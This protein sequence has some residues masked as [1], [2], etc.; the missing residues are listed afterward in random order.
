VD[1]PPAD[2]KRLG[3]PGIGGGGRWQPKGPTAVCST[4]AVARPS[5]HIRAP[6]FEAWGADGDA[7]PPQSSAPRYPAESA[8]RLRPPFATMEKAA[9]VC[10]SLGI[11]LRLLVS[12]RGG[13]V[14]LRGATLTWCKRPFFLDAGN[15]SGRAMRV[16]MR[17][18]PSPLSRV[19][20]KPFFRIQ[21][22]L[23][24][25]M[26]WHRIRTKMVG[27]MVCSPAPIADTG[28]RRRGSPAEPQPPPTWA[29]KNRWQMAAVLRE[30][31]LTF[32]DRA[33]ESFQ[34]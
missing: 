12:G 19:G 22:M 17:R 23:N 29:G 13:F 4:W 1:R 28:G 32:V 33:E 21:S 18:F 7:G 34:A 6:G 8:G 24:I 3:R 30:T 5:A 14:A 11:R 27:G 16:R 15:L 9:G 10:P 31:S 26:I 25:A 2:K 20:P